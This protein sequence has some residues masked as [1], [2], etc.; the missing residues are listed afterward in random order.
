MVFMHVISDFLN[1]T[2]YYATLLGLPVND[3]ADFDSIKVKVCGVAAYDVEKIVI[4]VITGPTC[5]DG[6]PRSKVSL[7]SKE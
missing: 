2:V 3:F 4:I 7:S 1:F 5:P 6:K